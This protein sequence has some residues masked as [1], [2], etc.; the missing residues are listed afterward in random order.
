[1]FIPIAILFVLACILF[2]CI[3]YWVSNNKASKIASDMRTQL[4]NLIDTYNKDTEELQNKIADLQQNNTRLIWEKW[5]LI[6]KIHQAKE[7]IQS[8]TTDL[9]RLNHC[10]KNCKC[11]KKEQPKEQIKRWRKPKV[12]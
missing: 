10:T 5:D 8:Y 9:E 7:T 6:E 3:W 1:M 4:E 2:Y 11:S 12:K